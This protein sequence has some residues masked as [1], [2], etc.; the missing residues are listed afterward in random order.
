MSAHRQPSRLLA[1]TRRLLQERE[2]LT[3]ELL[4]RSGQ[5][6]AAERRARAFVQALPRSPFAPSLRRVLEAKP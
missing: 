3:V 1:A 4:D 2:A 5:H 6:A